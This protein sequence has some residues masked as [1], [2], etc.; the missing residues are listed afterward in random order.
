MEC[1]L[2][3]LRGRYGPQVS[4]GPETQLPIEPVFGRHAASLVESD[5][6]TTRQSPQILASVANPVHHEG[7]RNE[8]YALTCVTAG[9]LPQRRSPAQ[10]S[11]EVISE[12]ADRASG[13]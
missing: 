13:L 1:P 4:G 9:R 3:F 12:K 7:H 8:C 11:V 10:I 6:K 2:A 5:T